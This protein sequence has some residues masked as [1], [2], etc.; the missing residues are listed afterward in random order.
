MSFANKL[1][2]KTRTYVNGIFCL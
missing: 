2:Y 1:D